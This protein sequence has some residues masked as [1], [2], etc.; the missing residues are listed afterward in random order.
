MSSEY[1][2]RQKAREYFKDWQIWFS[3]RVKFYDSDIFTIFDGCSWEK[4]KFIFFQLTTASNKSARIKKIINFMRPNNL[5]IDR[6]FVKAWVMAW[7][8]KKKK[9]IITEV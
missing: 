2:L 9:F 3:P 1:I 4:D 7:H 6:K 5:S 8:K